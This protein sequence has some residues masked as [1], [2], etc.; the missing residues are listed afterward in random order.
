MIEINQITPKDL[1]VNKEVLESYLSEK[2]SPLI[3]E[4][5]WMKDWKQ[6]AQSFKL[7]KFNELSKEEIVSYEWDTEKVKEI[8]LDTILEVQQHLPLENIKVTV[9]PALTFPWFQ[10]FDRSIWTYGFTNGPNNIQMAVPPNPDIEFLKYMI[11]HELHHATPINPIYNLTL[12]T[13]TLADWFKMEGGAEYFSLNLFEDKRWWKDDFTP[14]IESTYWSIAQYKI[15]TTDEDEKRPL[16]FGNPKIG[17]PYM[18]GYAFTYG[19][20]KNF[21]EKNPN[22]NFQDLFMIE[23]IEFID[24]YKIKV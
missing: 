17:I 6:M 11:A 24:A 1:Y 10:K 18:A 15:N 5:T 2:L 8:I 19:L 20:F 23:P 7:L 3:S 4:K 13:F 16:C 21:V 14:E 22:N 12:D 9:F